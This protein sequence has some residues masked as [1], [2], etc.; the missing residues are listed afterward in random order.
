VK[1]YLDAPKYGNGADPW[2][3]FALR[4]RSML[5]AMWKRRTRT[6]EEILKAASARAQ[7]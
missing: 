3:F 5:R 1:F 6:V 7:V 4:Y 2:V